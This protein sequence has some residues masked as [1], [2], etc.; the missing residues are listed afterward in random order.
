MENIMDR[1]RYREVTAP[2]ETSAA[3]PVDLTDET[4]QLHKK[5]YLLG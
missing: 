1:V 5:K 2:V 4:M 3:I